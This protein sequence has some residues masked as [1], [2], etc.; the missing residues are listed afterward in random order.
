MQNMSDLYDDVNSFLERISGQY[1]GV[2]NP[3][4]MFVRKAE[5]KGV[6]DEKTKELMSVALSVVLRC[7]GCIAFHV[8]KALDAGATKD[9]IVE[10]V[11][12]AVAMGG[13][14]SLIYG[15]LAIQA[16]ED[17]KKAR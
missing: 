16:I 13:G 6:L 8:K 4:L 15:R 1:P 5:G 9:E 17:F 7:D 11:F 10:S 14:P 2:V 12:V 3:F